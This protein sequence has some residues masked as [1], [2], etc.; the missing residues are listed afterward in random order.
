MEWK[1]WT[2]QWGAALKALQL[3]AASTPETADAQINAI[4]DMREA[5]FASMTSG[6]SGSRRSNATSR[7]FEHD[8]AALVEAVAP[9][10]AG[11]DAEDA[12]LDLERPGCEAKQGSRSRSRERDRARVDCRKRIDE[13]HESCR[14]AREVIGR[15]QGRS[16]RRN[17]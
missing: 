12:V 15:L 13:C 4:D 6:M 2:T 5:R 9:Q 16:R 14:D 1:D 10:L 7:A 11:K 8:V 3:P 17:D